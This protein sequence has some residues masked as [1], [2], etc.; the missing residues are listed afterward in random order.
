MNGFDPIIELWILYDPIMNNC[1]FIKHELSR[2][3]AHGY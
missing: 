2:D 3:N 1:V